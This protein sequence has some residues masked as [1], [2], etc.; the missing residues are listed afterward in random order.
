MKIAFVSIMEGTAWGGSEELWYRAAKE[1]N[2]RGFE[3]CSLTKKWQDIP[4]K[5]VELSELKIETLFFR[6]SSRSLAQRVFNS[7]KLFKAKDYV[8]PEVHADFYILSQGGTYDF[9]YRP[10]IMELIIKSGKPYMIISQHN[11]EHG[12]I[13]DEHKRDAAIN[14]IKM[15]KKFCFV[16]ARNRTTAERQLAFKFENAST[17]S[18]PSTLRQV[19]IKEFKEENKLL[20]ACVARLDCDFKGQDILLQI[21]STSKWKN[22]AFVLT[23]FGQ[24]RHQKYLETLIDFYNLKDK[25]TIKGHVEDVDNI[26]TH[27]HVLVLP[28]IS[29]G[30]SLALIEAMLS[31]RTAV[32]T[33]VG[34]SNVYV[35]NGETGFLADS[36]SV[37]A[38]ENA[39]EALWNN[40][41]N[42]K[43]L[44][45]KGFQNALA[46]TNL[47]P[48]QTLLSYINE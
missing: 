25:V 28:S 21:L 38:V 32:A 16:S 23:L 7:L 13:I 3:V 19:G 48:E 24:G 39:L 15:A 43:E 27:N 46:K 14:F 31:G 26:W 36:A 41:K 2:K 34:D 35:K 45:V 1:A 22:R 6:N 20:M 18:N 33:D 8:L 29:E 47:F 37:N 44:G 11:A 42:L 4:E 30:T 9:I 17:I 12:Q 40:R 5:I 10:Q